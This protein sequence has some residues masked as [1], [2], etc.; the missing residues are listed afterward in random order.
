MEPR[1]RFF[2]DLALGGGLHFQ[3]WNGEGE[4]SIREISLPLSFVC[5]V[6]RRLSLDVT[7]GSGVANLERGTSRSLGGLTDTQL[8][9]SFV[10]GDEV[11]LLTV[12][13]S[14]PT[15]QA[16]LDPGEQQVSN[17]LAQN[18]LGFRTPHFGQGLNANVGLAAARKL[19]ESVAGIGIGYLLKGEFSPW[20]GG[21]EYRP[22]DEL[23]LTVGLDR[24]IL[25]GDGRVSLD[26]VYTRYG[27]DEVGGVETFQ[28]GDKL[29]LQ[30]LGLCKAK[31]LD[32]QIYLVERGRGKNTNY[33]GGGQAAYSNGNQFEAR[34]VALRPP[35][36]RVGWRG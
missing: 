15:G 4:L 23:S 35:A 30:V 1:T 13:L 17:Y 5:P 31:G 16:E 12:G 25:N 28:S 8:R 26:V 27:K 14:L 36:G 33:W 32:W 2:R 34:L 29:L 24:Q 18:A 11:A 10:L 3:R 19:G 20:K 7:A 21:A 9:A 6:T 22:G